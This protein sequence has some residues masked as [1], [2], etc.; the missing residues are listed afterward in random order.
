MTILVI[1]AT[2]REAAFVPERFLLVVTGIGKVDAAAKTAAAVSE[3]RAEGRGPSLVVNIGTAGSLQ[4]GVRGLFFPSRVLNHDF[5]ADAV[6]ALG[7]EPEIEV[8]IDGGD[9]TV[10][11]TGD[12]FVTDPAVRDALAQHADLVDM[13]GFAIARTC[14]LLGVPVRLV[15]IVSDEADDSALD[16]VGAANRCA[17][18]LG[19]WLTQT[20]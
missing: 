16:W 5:D 19:A 2:R 6:R 12:Q 8:E 9:G 15:K 13:E 14:Q 11:A 7:Y 10:L 20:Y 4:P 18:D 1:A 3:L 17:A